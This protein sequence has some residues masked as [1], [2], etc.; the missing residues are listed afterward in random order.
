MQTLTLL[1]LRPDGVR[2]TLEFVFS[3]HPTNSSRIP[4]SATPQRQGA[5]ITH[6][7]VAMATKLLSSV[8]S[9]MTPQAWFEGISSQ[10]CRLMDGVDGSELSRTAAQIV[11]FGILGKKQLGAPGACF[12]GLN[13]KAAMGR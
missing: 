3:V 2:G 5:S 1:P 4:D 11:G 10:I 7:A 13:L 9:S 12:L 8:P 6:E